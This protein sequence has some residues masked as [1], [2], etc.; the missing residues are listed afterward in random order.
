MDDIKPI[1]LLLGAIP[2][3]G[4]FL[5]WHFRTLNAFKDDIKALEL[6][7]KDLEKTDSLQQQTIDKLPELYP[8]LHTLIEHQIKKKK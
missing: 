6:K 4:G 5:Y 8:L 3:I 1:T 7:M 2:I